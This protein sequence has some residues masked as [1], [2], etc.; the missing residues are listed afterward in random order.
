MRLCSVAE[1]W[2]VALA[3]HQLLTL[4]CL[5]VYVKLRLHLGRALPML[6]TPHDNQHTLML[7][8]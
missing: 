7:L 1:Q 4:L 2:R 5:L 6:C 8:E 3:H